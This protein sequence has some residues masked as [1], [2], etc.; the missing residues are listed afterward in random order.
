MQIE[1]ELQKLCVGWFRT[2]Y[3]DEYILHHSPNGGYRNKVEALNFKK[4]GVQPGFPDL[5]LAVPKAGY[6]GLF[7]ELKSG[8]GKLT[9]YQKNMLEKLKS[10]DYYCLVINNFNDFR[11][12]VEKY[13]KLV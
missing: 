13:L 6:H 7:V 12:E 10:Q 5:F 9:K 11:D 4:M 3:G 8:T 2:K 1:R